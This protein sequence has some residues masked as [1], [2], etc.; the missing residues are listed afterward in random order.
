MLTFVRT[1]VAPWIA[2]LSAMGAAA[3]LWQGLDV[4]AARG[5]VEARPAGVSAPQAG[6]IDALAV[7]P[8]QRVRAGDLIASLDAR[9]LDAE[10][11][12]L[13]AEAL[14]I[15]AELAA[16]AAET[17][18]KVGEAS[19]GIEESVEAAERALQV[20]RADRSV[21]AAEFAAMSKQLAVLRG[22]VDKRMADRRELDALAVKHSALE[23][24]LASAD[25]TIAQLAGQAAA[26]RARRGGVP[27]D[28]TDRATEPLRAE[29][30]VVRGREQLLRLRKESLA[31][32][33]AVDGEVS[34]VHV[35]PGE[36]VAAAAPIATIV[37]D[38]AGPVPPHVFVCLDE[39]AAAALAVGEAVQLH[40]AAGPSLSA[41]LE[42]LAPDV[43]QLPP[44]CW[45]DPRTPEWG[46]AAY[47][48][49]DEPAPLAPGQGFTVA[50][51]GRP[52]PH[53]GARTGGPVV[54]SA[55]ASSA[56]APAPQ[57]ATWAAPAAPAALQVPPSLR[58]RTRFEP[59]A[60]T[61]SPRLDRFVIASDD[62]GFD[63]RDEHV[64]WL[65]TMDVRGRVD[66]EPLVIAGVDALSDLE[67]IAP[68]PDGGLYVL[69]SQSTS[70][71][72]K[73]P[74]AR[75]RLV[76]VA[77]GDAGARAAAVV[78]LAR[79]LE[80][81]GPDV[82]AGLGLAGLDDLDIEGM[83]ATAG[84]GLLLGLKAPLGPRGALVW[85]LESPDALLATGRLAAGALSQ[86]AQI[87][88]TVTADGAAVPGGISELLELDDGTWMIA[89]TASGLDPRTQDGA[90][91]HVD[92]D[93]A[94]PR[95][96][97]S[98]PGLKPEGLAQSGAALV[99]VFDA[100]DDTPQW[101]EQRWPAP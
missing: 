78:H 36:L 56:P 13:A 52:S 97:R 69:A 65:F 93:S 41:H 20:A 2:W 82:L 68:A 9:E 4:A 94:A 30:A 80:G 55:A 83:T 44:R 5:F 62:T 23:K 28:A 98:F 92:P 49:V 64:P 24:E 59:S 11:E 18:F 96:V 63:G 19:R 6:R 3:W 10:L 50:F 39:Q 61:W 89:A 40:A 46:R 75:Q 77:L 71:K 48:A 84:G 86:R 31:L 91:F 57:P 43:A 8:G 60:L 22:L 25:A 34:A 17:Q 54:A 81:A 32:R 87:P 101:M 38:T 88:L 12:I 15:E 47:V 35:R 51:L 73:R 100:G 37:P 7:A 33:A 79:L 76:H 14:R 70:R 29:L 74:A 53:A 45:R 85:H 1:R 27:A 90:L 67:A 26:A 72:G 95:R 21:R 99:V 66:P 58:A 42:R 16:V